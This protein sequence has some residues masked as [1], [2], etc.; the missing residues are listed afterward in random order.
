MESQP[1]EQP[2]A[3]PTPIDAVIPDTPQSALNTIRGTV[4]VIVRVTIDKTGAVVGATAEEPGPSRYFERL[5]L[6]AARKW[7]FNPD[8]AHEQRTM[9]LKFGFTRS[10]VA[11]VMAA[12]EQQ[13]PQESG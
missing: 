3:P 8:P 12:Q 10:G 7:T 11:A 2:L 9:L 6:E 13:S 5:A 1:A 4:R